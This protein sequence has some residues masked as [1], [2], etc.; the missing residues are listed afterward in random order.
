[1]SE[2]DQKDQSI[3]ERNKHHNAQIGNKLINIPKLMKNYVSIRYADNSYVKGRNLN[4]AITPD[5]RKILQD[6]IEKNMYETADYNKLEKAEK[7]YLDDILS[8]TKVGVLNHRYLDDGKFK[9]DVKRFELL[10][11]QILSGNDSRE[12]LHEFKILLFKL[13]NHSL[14]SAQSFNYLC[15]Q[16]V[17]LGI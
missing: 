7:Q 10:K 1:M 14:I 8:F 16:L 11:D 3:R 4:R 6:I 5:L 13:K 2:T 15:A 17:I 9:N 12:L